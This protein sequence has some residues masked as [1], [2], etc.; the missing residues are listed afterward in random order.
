MAKLFHEINSLA[1]VLGAHADNRMKTNT[2]LKNTIEDISHQLKTPLAALNIY[3]GILQDDELSV[4]E[5]NRFINLS[6]K[7]LER[8]E[9]LI[10]NLLK[11]TKFDSGNVMFTY[12]E[13][14][15]EE[16]ILELYERFIVR[17]EHEKKKIVL[18]T[19][20]VMCTCDRIWT[21]EALGNLVKNA[22]DHTKEGGEIHLKCKK[23]GDDVCFIVED[24]GSGIHEDDIFY[25]FSR[26][27]RS[28]YSK[29][30]AGIGLGLS[31]AKAI[32]EN[33]RGLI[34]VESQLGKGSVFSVFLP[35]PTKL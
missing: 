21:M 11:L 26:F 3:N 18:H 13:E 23:S 32:I 17:A 2:F 12:A 4:E 14:S 7:E 34:E 19:E 22:L 25:I 24:N 15:A 1:D 30:V 20:D 28:R 8:M 27:Y 29:D 33:Q 35:N 16:M 10:Q 5:R 9:V 6:E 31:L